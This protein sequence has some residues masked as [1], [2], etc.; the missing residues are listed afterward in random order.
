[1]NQTDIQNIRLVLAGA[2]E[3][4][5]F[6]WG[7]ADVAA[8]AE[9]AAGDPVAFVTL[10]VWSRRVKI[11]DEETGEERPAEHKLVPFIP[12]P[13]QIKMIRMMS[14]CVGSG[15]DMAVAK[16]RETGVSVL[17]TAVSVWGWLFKGWD[18][19]LCSRTEAL[20]DRTGDP[21]TLFAKVEH[22]IKYLPPSWL[23][24]PL[25]DLLPGGK[26]RRHCILEHPDGN[27]IT[28]EATT[29]H[30]GRG[31]RKTVV[32]F[33]EAASQD[34]FEEGWRSAADTAA[35]RWAVSTH[36]VGSYFTGTLWETAKATH[37]PQ[38]LLLTYVDDPDKS[39]GGEARVDVDGS[40]TGDPGRGYWWSPWLER[41]MKRRDVHDLRENVF[42][43]PSSRGRSFFPVVDLERQRQYVRKP[44]RCEV[45][46]GELV[47]NPTGRWRIFQEPDE[48]SVLCSF[49]DPAYGTGAAN[50]CCVMMDVNQREVVA[51]FVDPAIPPYDLAREVVGAARSW[52][53]GRADMMIGWEVNGPGASMQHDFERLRWY[54]VFHHRRLGQR[55]ESRSKRV[56]WTSTRVTKRVLFGDLAR[57]IADDT[58][59]CP[60]GEILD[61]MESTVIYKDGGIGPARLEIDVSSGAR[62]AH[63]DRVIAFGGCVMLLGEV[64][65]DSERP[66]HDYGKPDYSW[67]T[68]LNMDND[69][70]MDE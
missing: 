69:I 16:S 25:A 33:D 2:K 31:A 45:V 46:R 26:R 9:L 42:A 57:A 62:D 58:V 50:A 4:E 38:D 30:I 34:R 22:V 20:V 70:V 64:N 37:D 36:L 39:A 23:P 8:W 10:G 28:G 51:T 11:V 66:V 44:R 14:E 17:S 13:A 47:D 5:E 60:D 35:S 59:I 21:D 18:V 32:L 55:V 67:R 24:C 52:A 1:M 7:A 40:I 29:S 6:G 3:P 68:M 12:W 63:G 65:P 41:Q 19:L 27:A 53:R 15:R 56:G 61:E 54:N 48:H 43:L 49:M